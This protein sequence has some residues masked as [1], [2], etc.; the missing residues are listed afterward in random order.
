M[1]INHHLLAKIT[2]D[3]ILAKYK[4]GE[5]KV[6]NIDSTSIYRT[7]CSSTFP[8]PDA[9]FYNEANNIAISFEFKPPTET[10]RGI[11]TGLGQTIA[12]LNSCNVSFLIIPDELEGFAIGDFMAEIYKKQISN[13]IPIGL[14]TYKNNNPELVSL[15]HH[16][17]ETNNHD[18][19]SSIRNNRFWAKHQ[20]M[21]VA[22]FHLLLH[23][24][25]LKKVNIC[26]DAFKYIWDKYLLPA[27]S[28]ENLAPVDI[29]D[30]AGS[31]IRT[32]SGTKNLRIFE[33][34][35]NKARLDIAQNPDSRI[36]I[37]RTL[38]DDASSSSAGDNYYNSLKKNYLSFLRHVEMIDSTESLTELGIKYYHLG[39]TNGPT[40]KIFID[41]FIK[42]ILTTGH[43]IELIFDYDSLCKKYGYELSDTDLK[44]KMYED[45]EIKGMIKRN[46]NRAAS[47]NSNVGPF[48][49]EFILWNSLNLIMSP[50]PQN[51][52]SFN[53]KKITESCSLPDL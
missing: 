31:V 45:Y 22:L 44:K 3:S 29:N 40:S 38:Q 20:D 16:V 17:S 39:L 15:R 42:L 32:L 13:K 24:Y 8:S 30:V 33:K 49:Y 5:W 28:I 46:P 10:K 41:Y 19:Y 50:S 11:L 53:W 21:P 52:I 23:C 34:K 4:S 25:Y 47:S 1:S 2:T 36:D 6:L 43:H 18:I 12:Y 37:I 51:K 26:E 9:M 48:K 35:I 27:G 14:V 7:G